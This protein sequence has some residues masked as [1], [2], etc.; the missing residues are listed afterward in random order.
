ML[1]GGQLG[2]M[3][4]QEATNYDVSVHV[5]DGDANAPCKNTSATFTHGSITDFDSVYAFGKDKDVITVEIE[6]VNIEALEK[7]EKEGKNRWVKYK[8]KN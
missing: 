3:F 8:I 1:G 5:M 4:I 6:N 7:L 2:R